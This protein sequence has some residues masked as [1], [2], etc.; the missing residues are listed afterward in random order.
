MIVNAVLH[1]HA[2]TSEPE[3]PV[4][5]S[6]LAIVENCLICYHDIIRDPMKS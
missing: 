4:A 3:V 6:F 2:M 5:T 1:S